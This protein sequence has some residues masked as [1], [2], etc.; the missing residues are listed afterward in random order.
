MRD[1]MSAA[2]VAAAAMPLAL[3]R[4]GASASISS[5]KMT[6]G[7]RACVRQQTAFAGMEML[8]GTMADKLNL[9][10]I[11]QCCNLE[12]GSQT[13]VTWSATV[14]AK[15]YPSSVD[16]CGNIALNGS[17]G[18]YCSH[19]CSGEDASQPGLTFAVK[20]RNDVR[21]VDHKQQRACRGEQLHVRGVDV[22][23]TQVML[24]V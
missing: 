2:A 7:P 12:L 24:C 20:L 13:S 22:R 6:D 5:M 1:A 8:A 16:F 9:I 3:W 21:A 18:L 23:C 15:L 4:A 10:H 17:C 19:L 11:A 14:E